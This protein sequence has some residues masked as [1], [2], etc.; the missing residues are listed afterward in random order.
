MKKVLRYLVKVI[1]WAVPGGHILL[2]PPDPKGVSSPHA[3]VDI[4]KLFI[5][6]MIALTIGKILTSLDP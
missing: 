3:L 1:V 2:P 6:I 5:W 4:G